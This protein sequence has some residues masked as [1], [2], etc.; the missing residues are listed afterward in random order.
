[1]QKL[2]GLDIQIPIIPGIRPVTSMNHVIAAEEIF[3]ANV[4]ASLKNQLKT[5]TEEQKRE[6]CIN[7]TLKLIEELKTVGAPGVHMFTMNDIDIIEEIMAK[8]S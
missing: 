7:F 8:I 2:R 6:I 3:G 4:P 1:M 5:A